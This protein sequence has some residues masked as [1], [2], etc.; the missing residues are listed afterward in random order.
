[1]TSHPPSGRPSVPPSGP[2]SG[3]LS[4]P[5][6]TP[7]SAGPPP[8]SGPPRGGSGGGA[9]GSGGGSGGGPGGGG[10]GGGPSG[11]GGGPAGGGAGS[12]GGGPWW[13]SVPKV[14][15]ITA[16]LVAAIA[17]IVVLTRP[18]GNGGGSASGG[19]GEVFLQNAAATGPDP[20]TPST[21]RAPDASPSAVPLPSPTKSADA[22]ATRSVSGAAPGLYGGTQNVASCDVE[23]QV[24][25]LAAEPA[26]N[27]AFASVLGI[28]ANEVPG[29]LRS[30]TPLQL[31]VDT[32][33]TN[34]GYRSGA[35]TT[36][37]SVLQAGTAVLV[38]DRGVPRVRCACGNPLTPP[39]AQKS[40]KTTG[41][42]WPGYDASQVVVVAPSV[43]VVNVFVVYDPAEGDWFAREPGDTGN[44]DKH[45]TAPTAPPSPSVSDSGSTSPVPCFTGA[46][47]PKPQGR[48]TPTPCPSDSASTPSTPL[49]P[50]SPE[51]PLA[52]VS[53][54]SPDSPD[55]PPPPDSG[56]PP[57]PQSL[58]QTEGS[59]TDGTTADQ[60]APGGSPLSGDPAQP[61]SPGAPDAGAPESGAVAPDLQPVL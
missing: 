33:V 28:S 61:G 32:R 45:T 31:R 50:V 4:G 52:P 7:G 56:S 42:A 21:A 10:S 24:R 35:A 1:M 11:T 6:T 30:L 34:H 29:Y 23:Q 44:K 12:G 25:F 22:N 36:Y 19:G 49:S 58:P 47:P 48:I 8:P 39:V 18:D 14:A 43:T 54:A 40:P 37:Q 41:A 5:S 55:S 57:A 17:L 60:S 53:P 15:S 26:K 46:E 51:S 16:V 13:R 38:D 20:F 59:T 9:G 3:P 2:P 27:A